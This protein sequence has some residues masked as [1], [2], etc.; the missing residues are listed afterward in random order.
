MFYPDRKFFFLFFKVSVSQVHFQSLNYGLPEDEQ[1][2]LLGVDM[3]LRCKVT[4]LLS[5]ERWEVMEELYP[6]LNLVRP[7]D[8]NALSPL[9]GN[10]HRTEPLA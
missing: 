6:H 8:I 1:K 3:I 5:E 4:W 2:M 7:I 10:Y 9:T